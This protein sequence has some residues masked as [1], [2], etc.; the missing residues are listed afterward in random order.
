MAERVRIRVRGIVQGV[1]YRPFVYRQAVR[2]GVSGWVQN[3]SEGVLLEAEGEPE[4]LRSLEAALRDDAPPA[5]SVESVE[6]TALP[7]VRKPGFSILPSPSGTATQTLVSPD[8]AICEDC[9]RELLMPSDRR[10]GYPFINC[11]NCGPR[12]SI[13]RSV[14]YD[15]PYTTMAEFPMCPDCQ[16]EYADPSDR[17]FHA[18]PDACGVCGPQYRF[19]PLRSA[20]TAGLPEDP[21]A[22]ARFCIAEGKI[23]AIKGI[24]GYHLAC[25][26]YNAAAVT[27]LR[28]RKLREDKPFAVMADCL[29]TVK[30]LC[31]VSSEEERLLTS[32]AAPVVLLR[33]KTAAAG[34]AAAVAP[35]NAYLGV[36]LPYA[37]VQVLLL[38]PGAVWVMTSANRSEEPI[39]YRD[40]DA[41][42]RLTGI[43]DA[44]LLHNRRIENRVDDSVVRVAGGGR[45]LLRRGRGFAPAPLRLSLP[46]P[47]PV[48]VLAGGAELKNT[49][50]LTKGSLGFVSE[51]V[52]DLENQATLSSYAYMI[53][54][55]EALFAIRPQLLAC[56]LHP[57][58]LSTQYCE[59]RAAREGLPLLRIQHHY[60]HIASVLAEQGE[61]EPV[62]GVAFDGTGLG[63]DGTLWGGEFLQADLQGFQRLGHIFSRPLPG[64]ERAAREPWRQALWVLQELYGRTLAARR[65]DFAAA[66][67]A[68]WELL[69]AAAG[70]GLNAPLSSSAGR[71]FDTAA[72]LLGVRL[73]NHYEGQAAV[74]LE[75]LAVGSPRPGRILDYTVR[76][77]AG[78]LSVDFLPV[79]Q[80]LS[81][82]ASKEDAARAGLALDFHVTLAAAVAGVMHSLR[83]QTGIRK[84]VL[85]G[86]VFQNR[87]LLEATVAA[88]QGE[89]TVLLNRQVPPNDGGVAL[90]QAAVA[91]ARYGGRK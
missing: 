64:G 37:P 18:Q 42:A 33:K 58:Y 48:S 6:I 3:D 12:Y 34:L 57:D 75:Q 1:G 41:M 73:V 35:G 10:Y 79:L 16:R 86:G 4:V 27:L 70:R 67:P 29:D 8:L 52:G 47:L 91:S 83:Q 7:A 74:E 63:A 56:D 9:R 19:V 15:R 77:D 26:A 78:M 82:G 53:Q 59:Q 87:L 62:L 25:D 32:A 81:E 44:F 68:G 55:Y 61:S 36:M 49:F 13:I 72:A 88:L 5:A 39:A 89:F 31:E 11:T 80:Q 2:R 76:P 71:L 24:G 14:P 51:H 23:V 54:H 46:K 90:G 43:A 22:A 65:P 38:Q 85:S 17:R 40:D 21:I 84:A 28:Q 20:D 66:L 60:A 45:Q 30:K 50:C 69:L